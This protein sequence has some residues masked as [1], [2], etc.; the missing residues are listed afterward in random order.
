MS[1]TRSYLSAST[2]VA[3]L[4]LCCS[5]AVLR[6]EEAEPF[7]DLPL[8]M[9]TPPATPAPTATPVKVEKGSLKVTPH[10]TD[11]TTVIFSWAG[12][13]SPGTNA[14]ILAA[15]TD[16]KDKYKRVHLVLASGGGSVNEGN[17]LIKTLKDITKTHSLTTEV[18]NG[19][20]CWS[21]CVF[22]YLQGQ[23]RFAARG[24]TWMFHEVSNTDPVTHKPTELSRR[25]WDKLVDAY[26]DSAGVSAAWTAQ[27][28]PK[29]MGM[30]YYQ[31]GTDL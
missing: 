3:G 23:T 20:R 1:S 22:V 24:T 19:Q 21:M 9:T 16:A 28:R 2:L 7:P 30:D 14:D 13:I 11:A 25:A 5:S 17:L 27:M 10:P 29:T 12:R 15:F 18:K 4:L 31:S 8:E 26:F 6:A